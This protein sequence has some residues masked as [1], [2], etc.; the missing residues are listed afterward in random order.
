MA[1]WVGWINIAP[2]NKEASD[3]RRLEILDQLHGDWEKA[4]ELDL[5][6]LHVYFTSCI[7]NL[8]VTQPLDFQEG[9][10]IASFVRNLLVAFLQE[11]DLVRFSW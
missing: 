10:G 6:G 1:K 8:F 9:D 4:V 5:A 7:Y 3:N 2:G 11:V